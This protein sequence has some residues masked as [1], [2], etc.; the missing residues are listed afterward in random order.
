MPVTPLLEHGP[1]SQRPAF[2]R[3][4]DL[5]LLPDAVVGPRS[6]VLVVGDLDVVARELRRAQRE[7]RKAALVVGVDELVHRRLDVGED[8]EPGEGVLTLERAQHAG[9]DGLAAD[10]VEPVAAREHVAFDLV[11][12]ALVDEGDARPLR[13]EVVDRDVVRLEEELKPAPRAGGDQILDDLG[14]AVDHDRAARQLAKRHPMALPFELEMDAV[15][16][17]PL[18]LEPRADADLAQQVGV[19]LL[20]HAGPDALLGSTRGCAPRR[21]PT[22]S[23]PSRGSAPGSAPPG[24][25]RRCRPAFSRALGEHALEDVERPVRGSDAAVDGALEQHL[26]DLLRRHP[27]APRRADVHRELVEMAPGCERGERHR[28][29]GLAVEPRPGPDLA[30]LRSG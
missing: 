17:D 1:L 27:V 16:H 4:P 12:A 29:A 5:E 13:H 24:P 3:G 11:S 15:V 2:E 26:A 23:P 25:R 10:A 8:A 14:L 19:P 18:A 28:A 20:D 21:R 7:E 6:D 22:R 9:R 30:P